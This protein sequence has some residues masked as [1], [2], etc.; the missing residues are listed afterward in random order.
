MPGFQSYRL[1]VTWPRDGRK[2][3]WTLELM[4]WGPGEFREYPRGKKS[5]SSFLYDD[6]MV[7]HTLPI[8]DMSAR[9]MS[10]HANLLALLGRLKNKIGDSDE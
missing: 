4:V 8:N 9:D 3:Y 7:I 5:V 10:H 6:K 2:E 1:V